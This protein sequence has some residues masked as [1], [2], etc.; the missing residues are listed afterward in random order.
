MGQKYS[1]E[2]VGSGQWAEKEKTFS[3]CH[4]AFL[5]CY[6]GVT[7]LTWHY[8]VDDLQPRLLRTVSNQMKNDK[9]QMTNGKC[10]GLPCP[11]PTAHFVS[12]R[13]IAKIPAH[14]GE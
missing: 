4:L 11:Q 6:F 5:I 1:T 14:G 2:I 9:C 10:F 12:R 3:I 13:Y 8:A 7:G